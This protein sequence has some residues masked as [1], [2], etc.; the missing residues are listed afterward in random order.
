MSTKLPAG[1][2]VH[3]AEPE[4]DVLPLGQGGQPVVEANAA[5]GLKV[6]VSHLTHVSRL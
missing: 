6:L 2:T 1:Q 5:S 3:L 4:G